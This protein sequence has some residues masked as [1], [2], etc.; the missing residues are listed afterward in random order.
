VALDLD[1]FGTM[2]RA[3]RERRGL[4]AID[5][6][7]AMRWAGTAPVYRYER[8]GP[9]APRPD[10]DTINLLA[11]VLELG[12]ADRMLL[13][14][15]AGHLPDT[16]PLTAEEERRLVAALR[17]ELDALPD[18]AIAFDFR[19]RILTINDALPREFGSSPT[20]AHA[21]QRD[22]LTVFDL[23]WDPAL[24]LT[25]R[26]ID[27]V[28]AR[29][30]QVLRFILFNQLRRHETWYRDVPARFAHYDGFTALW[31]SM[32]DRA[33]GADGG[34]GLIATVHAPVAVRFSNGADGR[35]D[36]SLRTVHGVDGLV[37]LLVM[38]PV[39]SDDGAA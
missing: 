3:A 7:V 20:V 23:V 24:G 31:R 11:Q 27:P 16:E 4:R 6:A 39:G 1:A 33:A 29:R 28:A 32:E 17:P 12:Y 30:F 15:L 37:A 25:E 13:L 35:Y 8:G 14:G 18:P 2:V 38:S 10:P 34:V 5:L 22:G 9:D 21:W 36:A 26:L 19:G